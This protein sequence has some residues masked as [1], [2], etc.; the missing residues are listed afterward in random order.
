M[1][2]LTELKGKIREK[3]SSYRECAKIAG[4]SLNTFNSRMNGNTAFDIIEASKLAT[5]LEIPEN[6]IKYFFV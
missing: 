4:I 1:R 3:K 6:E 5:H 2:E